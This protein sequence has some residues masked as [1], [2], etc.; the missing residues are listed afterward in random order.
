MTQAYIGKSKNSSKKI[1]YDLNQLTRHAAVVGTTGSGKTVM[2]K[3]IVEEA[4]AAGIPVIAIDPKGDIGSLGI[5]NEQFDFRPFGAMAS[6]AAQKVA[7]KY[8]SE[9]KAQEIPSEKIRKLKQVKTTIYTPK[10]TVGKSLSLMPKLTI[11]VQF[12]ADDIN[13]VSALVDPV[14]ASLISLAELTGRQADRTQSL[15]SAIISHEWSASRALTI[16]KLIELFIK[17]PFQDLGSLP[18]ED[19]IPL[20]ERK[21]L[22]AQLNLILSSS[23]K[24]V[25]TV[26][27]DLDIATL[28]SQNLLSVFDLRY[29]PDQNEKQYVVE[30]I[31]QEIYKYILGKGGSEELKYI[32]YID[33]LAGF[34]PAPPANPATKRQLELLIRQARA[35]GLG[36]IVATQNPGDIDYKIFGNI[37]SRFIG[38]L[39]TELDM[40]KVAAGMDMDPSTLR[41][42]M[43]QLEVGDFIYN[44]AV[45]N[46]T[47]LLHT[48]WL[49]SY[50]GGPLSTNE[51]AWINN[52]ASWP[53]QDKKLAASKKTLS[54][55]STENVSAESN[56]V[57]AEQ[58]LAQTQGLENADEPMLNKTA[59]SAL[60]KIVS[61]VKERADV[62]Q[63]KVAISDAKQFTPHLR[64][65][66]EPKEVEGMHM[67]TQG[68]YV[69]DLT[70][71]LI[72]IDNYLREVQFRT[73]VEDDISIEK[74]TISIADAMR[75]AL[76]D[77]KHKLKSP[78]YNSKILKISSKR[79]EELVDLTF[80]KIKEKEQ[81][82]YHKIT[83]KT[84]QQVEKTKFKIE[85]KE[86][87]RSDLTKNIFGAKTSRFVKRLFGN[88]RLSAKTSEM[89][90]WK[91]K[92]EQLGKEIDRFVTQLR[93]LERKKEAQMTILDA[94]LQR[95]AQ[96]QV[97]QEY[98]V[99]TDGDLKVIATILLVPKR[100]HIL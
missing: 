35:F 21:K 7:D 23:S 57:S 86:D 50:H 2:C 92:K 61:Q 29:V 72:P 1:T 24:K 94:R 9:H 49:Y 32:L 87:E 22:A 65:V 11:P 81:R 6:G 26:G 95:K 58:V 88:D 51:I 44:N 25:W 64:I 8:A 27:E 47:Q 73:F 38:K 41:E 14:A 31:L 67:P 43:R 28:F 68:P 37:G 48:R 53:A 4:L 82:L 62:T 59:V 80:A 97:V 75:Y 79:R 70:S 83:D 33:E 12:D 54:S 52:P 40:E 90:R 77:A 56:A 55:Q 69:F 84:Q 34:I 74:T 99:P 36:I 30:V 63:L 66:I 39:R 98:Y 18:L 16:P 100:S 3:I 60:A 76:N 71:K 10:S 93:D 19:V 96:S 42:Q 20:K 78:Y 45:K 17:P 5:I 85:Q 15:V 89:V 46:N 13:S 91:L